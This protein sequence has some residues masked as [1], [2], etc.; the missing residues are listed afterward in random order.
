M[1][2]INLFNSKGEAA[3]TVDFAD[4]LLVLDRGEQAVKDVVVATLNA[5]RAGTASTL[6]KGEVAKQQ[7]E[8]LAPEGHR[9]RAYRFAAVA[10]VAR[11]WCG[12][13]SPA[14]LP[15]RSTA[16]WRAWPSAVR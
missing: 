7:Q 3:G 16:R 11:W 9:A 13:D 14:A 15:P 6:S 2:K 5:R 12:Q 8:A 4:D 1:S 10:G